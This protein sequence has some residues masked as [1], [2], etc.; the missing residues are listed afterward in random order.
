MPLPKV[1]EQQQEN[2]DDIIFNFTE[3]TSIYNVVRIEIR[4]T[5]V[6]KFTWGKENQIDKFYISIDIHLVYVTSLPFDVNLPFIGKRKS[7]VNVF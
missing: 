2:K 3:I 6:S 7:K 1:I 4:T 5:W